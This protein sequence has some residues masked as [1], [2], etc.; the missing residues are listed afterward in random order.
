MGAAFKSSAI[1]ARTL[2]TYWRRAGP[3]LLIGAV[4][5]VP[6]GLIDALANRTGTLEVHHAGDLA[7]VTNLALIAG[8]VAQT[9]TGLLGDVFYS[10]AVA[11]LL[12]RT[13]PGRRFSFGRVARR[14]SYGSLIAID[15]LLDFGVAIGLLL[16]I[17][18]GVCVFTWFALA[19]PLVEL[20]GIG[21]RAALARSWH[22]VRGSFLR[23][24]AVLG[25]IVLV[26]DAL[27]G[28]APAAAHGALGH[29]LLADW[30]VESAA[31]VL[32]TPLYAV[33]AVLIALALIAADREVDSARRDS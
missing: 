24:L 33:A 9:A 29:G 23:V 18:P 10:G 5:F 21:A 20:E 27:G 19:A 17:V 11:E 8:F 26:T 30:I 3:L 15:L 13:P 6:L 4:V 28:A 2:A 16:L 25:P 32:L 12:A 22:L 1:Y 31:N 7:D 14:L